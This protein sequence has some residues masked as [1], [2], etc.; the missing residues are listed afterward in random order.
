MYER[1]EVHRY[2]TAAAAGVTLLYCADVFEI[3]S[4]C[5]LELSLVFRMAR[6]QNTHTRTATEAPF[7]AVKKRTSSSTATA[8]PCLPKRQKRAV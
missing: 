5:G 8:I 3:K 1:C 6:S 7:V 4:K 2:C